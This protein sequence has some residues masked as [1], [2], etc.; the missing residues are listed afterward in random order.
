MRLKRK[1]SILILTCIV[2][3][4]VGFW[5]MQQEI[6]LGEDVAINPKVKNI[7]GEISE[8]YQVQYTSI[9]NGGKDSAIKINI[10]DKNNV[11]EVES[12]LKNNLFEDDLEHY[13]IDVS[14]NNKH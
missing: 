2:V 14:Y 8:K 4:S 13:E 11:Q 1:L 5:Y 7:V 10:Y 12:F 9:M 3:V 6:N